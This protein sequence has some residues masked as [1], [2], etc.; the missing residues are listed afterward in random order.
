VR[1]FLLGFE[2]R[3]RRKRRGKKIPRRYLLKIGMWGY[4]EEVR[5][6]NA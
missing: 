5:K 4:R 3:E 2:K 1:K 6:K